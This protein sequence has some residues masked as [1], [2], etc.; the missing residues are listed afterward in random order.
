MNSIVKQTRIDRF[1]TWLTALLVVGSGG[2]I[3]A[4][5]YYAGVETVATGRGLT[6]SIVNVVAEQTTRTVQTVDQKMQLVA[7]QLVRL[8]VNDPAA[9]GCAGR[10]TPRRRAPRPLRC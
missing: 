6:R 3:A 7:S 5:L 1:Q 4:S 10:S 8:R 2:M 9:I